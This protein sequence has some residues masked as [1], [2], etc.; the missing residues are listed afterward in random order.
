M[1]SGRF[2]C[3]DRCSHRFS[4]V[5]A[6]VASPLVAS[7]LRSSAFQD[8]QE[9]TYAEAELETRGFENMAGP[10]KALGPLRPAWSVERARDEPLKDER[11]PCPCPCPCT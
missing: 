10:A 11:V 7:T 1:F 2:W 8:L 6:P 3:G 9:R 4:A 5:R